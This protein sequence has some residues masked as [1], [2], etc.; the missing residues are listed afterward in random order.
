MSYRKWGYF[1][2]LIKV[3]LKNVIDSRDYVLLK[4]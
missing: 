3:M 1:S 2:A 4:S